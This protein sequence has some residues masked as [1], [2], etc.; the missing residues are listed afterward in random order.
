VGGCKNKIHDISLCKGSEDIS[1]LVTEKLDS[2]RVG[3]KLLSETQRSKR[4]AEVT[5]KEENCT[6][7]YTD[8]NPAEIFVRGLLLLRTSST[9]LQSSSTPICPSPSVSYARTNSSTLSRYPLLP[10]S[11]PLEA[12]DKARLAGLLAKVSSHRLWPEFRSRW[13]SNQSTPGV[14]LPT[15]S[16]QDERTHVLVIARSNLARSD[17][18]TLFFRMR[19]RRSR[20]LHSTL[21]DFLPRSHSF[22]AIQALLFSLLILVASSYSY[23]IMTVKLIMM[24]EH[25]SFFKVIYQ[26]VA[27]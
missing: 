6:Y 12:R 1:C 3:V 9:I 7:R 22:V 17:R 15:P 8:N 11:K 16:R 2:V 25:F 26:C 24:C 5:G 10:R 20:F 13:F 21:V 23:P 14:P 18:M 4:Q 19:Q 27:S